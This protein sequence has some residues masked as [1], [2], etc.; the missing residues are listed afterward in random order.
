MLLFA[1]ALVAL[2]AA[3]GQAP[4]AENPAAPA[5]ATSWTGC[6]A[7]GSTPGAFRLNLDEGA[8]AAT[9]ADPSSLGDPFVQLLAGKIDLSNHV[10]HRVVVRGTQ[11][12]PAEAERL[13]VTRP[14]HQEANATAAGTGGRAERHLR[15]VR[16]TSVKQLPGD[17]K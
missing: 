3:A 17:C 4:T 10:G 9:P 12:S 1:V 7:A 2:Q 16:V 14:D 6:V 5:P 8:A 11:L 15:Y 13:A